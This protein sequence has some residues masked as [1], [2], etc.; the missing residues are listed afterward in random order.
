MKKVLVLAIIVVMC[1]NLIGC[2]QESK[3][4]YKS[5]TDDISVAV[6]AMD[7][8]A[9]IQKEWLGVSLNLPYLYSDTNYDGGNNDE[10]VEAGTSCY[11]FRKAAK[12]KMEAAKNA[13]KGGSGDY[14]NAVQEYYLAANAYLSFVSN[15]PEGYSKITWA[16]KWTELRQA[17]DEAAGKIELY[18]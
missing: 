9:R 4:D 16:Q 7:N 17:C 8:C 11:E 12:E 5:I 3:I 13:L 14:C 2:A 10:S 6:I 15:F 1:C 18:E